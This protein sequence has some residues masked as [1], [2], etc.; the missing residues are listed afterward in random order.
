ML[1][2]PQGVIPID[3]PNLFYWIKSI[4]H[5]STSKMILIDDYFPFLAAIQFR[6]N[7]ECI[8]VWHAAGAF[9]TFG[10]CD[11]SILKRRKVALRRFK[12]VYNQFHKIVVG[13]EEMAAIF[14]DAFGLPKERLL[15]TG[16][17]KT[18]FLFD[19]EEQENARKFFSEKYPSYN[20]KKV[21]LYAPTFRDKQLEDFKIQLD[22]D[23]MYQ[24]LGSN[25]ILLIKLHPA[26]K[27]NTCFTELYPE[28]VFDFSAYKGINELLVIVDF[29][30]TDYSSVPFEFA[31]FKK[32][33]IFYPYDL[34]LYKQERGVIPRYLI[35][36]PGPIAFETDT[37]IKLI[38]NHSFDLELVADF[39]SKW[40]E[41]STGQS[42]KALVHYIVNKI[43]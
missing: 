32:P 25:Y 5:L 13:S 33:I 10:L 42:S 11:K 29:L 15:K 3:S 30:I 24:E 37:I 14:L 1:R 6:A 20:G 7:V 21:I 16:I 18:D 38:T 35:R 40:N 26:V 2:K 17:P 41:Y 8:Q 31:M 19:K 9:K 28:F 12:K 23:K 22:V 43:T 27:T 39:A 34:Q 36:T 4:Y